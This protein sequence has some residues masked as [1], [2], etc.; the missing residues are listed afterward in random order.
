MSAADYAGDGWGGG[1][2]VCE[3]V[4]QRTASLGDGA[5]VASDD[6]ALGAAQS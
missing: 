2:L 3:S 4:V 1:L 6:V 5:G